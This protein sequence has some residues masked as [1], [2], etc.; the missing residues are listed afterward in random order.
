M[1]Y[2]WFTGTVVALAL[3][4]SLYLARQ[5]WGVSL[6]HDGGDWPRVK[7]WQLAVLIGWTLVPPLW[8]IAE[9]FFVYNPRFGLRPPID[10]ELFKYSQ[11]LSAKAWLA[12]SSTL[13]IL[14]FGKDLRR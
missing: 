1:D 13:L 10:F 3:I 5:G 2:K 7:K 14:Y 6:P 9:F 8:L 12:V 4:Y 11:D